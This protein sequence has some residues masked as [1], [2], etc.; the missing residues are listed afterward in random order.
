VEQQKLDVRFKPT[1][2]VAAGEDA[3]SVARTLRGVLKVKTHESI[4]ILTSKLELYDED[5]NPY[6]PH[7]GYWGDN[8]FQGHHILVVDKADNSRS[9]L[10]NFVTDLQKHIDTQKAAA[11]SSGAPWTDVQVG[12]FVLHNKRRPKAADLPAEVVN[13]RYFAAEEC[14]NVAISYPFNV[15]E[16]ETPA[17]QPTAHGDHPQLPIQRKS[18]ESRSIIRTHSPAPLAGDTRFMSSHYIEELI[19]KAVDEQQLHDKFKPTLLLAVSDDA[20][21]PARLLRHYLRFRSGQDVPTLTHKLDLYDED[22]NPYNPIIGSWANNSLSGHR[23]LLVDKADSTRTAMS[24]FLAE[25]Q[26]HVDA[27]RAAAPPS[28]AYVDPVMGVFVLHNKD[29]P[30]EGQLPAD[31]LNY[32]YFVAENIRDVNIAYP[33]HVDAPVA[34]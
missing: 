16:K 8:S 32:R 22:A 11:A 24:S 33:F 20:L 30:K 3:L 17:Q 28:P 2:L 14:D 9:S 18:S 31:L 4:P 6:N 26:A 5:A 34:N 19:E 23:V 21:A 13:G 27:Q 12:V 7:L 10:A 25:L 15:Q 1:L 29:K